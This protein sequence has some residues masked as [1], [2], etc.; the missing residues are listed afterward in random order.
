MQGE[1]SM[2]SCESCRKYVKL[3]FP[4][5][6]QKVNYCSEICKNK[7]IVFHSDKCEYIESDPE[8]PDF[9]LND[10]SINYYLYF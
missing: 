3:N 1:P 2:E 4:C 7:D 9:T 5:V 8:E 6:C 10:Q